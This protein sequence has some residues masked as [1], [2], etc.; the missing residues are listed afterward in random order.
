MESLL[1]LRGVVGNDTS[2]VPDTVDRIAES[3]PQ[4]EPR[5][6]FDT[7]NFTE[8][9]K[10][11]ARMAR[12]FLGYGDYVIIFDL[13]TF[14]SIMSI[15]GFPPMFEPTIVLV[16][17]E[18]KVTATGT[19]AF[20][21]WELD[22]E[23]ERAIRPVSGGYMKDRPLTQEFVKRTVEKYKKLHG[24]KT[25]YSNP[26]VLTASPTESLSDQCVMLSQCMKESL[27]ATEV[28]ITDQ[29]MAAGMGSGAPV[30]EPCGAAVVDIG[31]G[32][33]DINII[34]KLSQVSGGRKQVQI[35]GMAFTEAI[36][37][38]IKKDLGLIIGMPDAE[39][40]KLQLGSAIKPTED[41]GGPIQV[42]GRRTENDGKMP[43]EF[44]TADF[45]FEAMDGLHKQFVDSI[46]DIQGHIL[47]QQVEKIH[48][49]GIVLTGGG[50][51]MRGLVARLRKVGLTAVVAENA[52][53]CVHNGL[54]HAYRNPDVFAKVTREYSYK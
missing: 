39:N 23:N 43:Y 53:L 1:E 46:I 11:A 22:S 4:G 28:R 5:I 35:G 34:S 48:K 9:A 25:G 26:L 51:K 10:N 33:T 21:S 54:L 47:P 2:T 38:R 30:G 36:H 31:A 7:S 49:R 16:D 41:F 29:G 13:G 32:T 52:Q 37:A 44:I 18:G 8:T 3:I 6:A 50:S 27:K 15:N 45:V 24:I 12:T 40:L 14:M 20:P 42:F 19:D 17:K